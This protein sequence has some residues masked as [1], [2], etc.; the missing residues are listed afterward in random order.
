MIKI[1]ND[2]VKIDTVNTS[3]ILASGQNTVFKVYYGK[4]LN[5]DTSYLPIYNHNVFEVFSSTDDTYYSNTFM[6]C[7]GEGNN[8][9]T[10]VRIINE[11]TTFV[12]RFQFF[13]FEVVDINEPFN[14]KPHSLNKLQTLKITYKD[15]INNIILNQYISI[16]ENSDVISSKCVAYLQ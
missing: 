10:M 11:D 14:E 6:S 12:S 2:Y 13:K 5:D 7:N 16:F 9:E 8:I 3:L 15:I 1:F 4:K